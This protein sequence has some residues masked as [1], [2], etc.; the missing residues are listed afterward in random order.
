MNTVKNISCAV[1]IGLMLIIQLMNPTRAYAGGR[2]PPPPT[3]TPAS[4]EVPVTQ[5]PAPPAVAIETATPEMTEEAVVQAPTTTEQTTLAEIFQKLPVKIHV[6]ALNENGKALPLA[7]EEAADVIA[8]GDP[9]WCPAGQAPTPGTN[10]C[11][12]SYATLG[13]LVA[14]EGANIAADGTIWITTGVIPDVNVVTIDGITYTNWANNALTL[15]GGWDGTTG[16]TTISSN[17]VF[18]VPI[19]ITNWNTGI[20]IQ[21][22]DAPS[23]ALSNVTISNGN[24]ISL[25][26]ENDI[27]GVAN[28]NSNVKLDNVTVTGS[29]GTGIYVNTLGTITANNI[30]ANE[31]AVYGAMLQGEGGVTIN[32]TNEF[33]S[34]GGG[35]SV[36][37]DGDITLSNV[38]ATG[39][40]SW[41]AGLTS[42]YGNITM[43]GTNEF[44]NNT[45]H[46]FFARSFGDM[47]LNRITA[48]GNN[49]G[50]ELMSGGTMTVTGEFNSNVFNGLLVSFNNGGI[51]LNQVT[52]NWNGDTGI[53][54]RSIGNI[55]LNQVT[56][57]WNGT[58]NDEWN[59]DSGLLARSNGDFTLNQV[60]AHGNIGVGVALL[61]EEGDGDIIASNITANGNGGFGAELFSLGSHNITVTGTN[62][63]NDNA[64]LGLHA[65]TSGGNITLNNV[66]ANRNGSAGADLSSWGNITLTGTNEFND[67]K[68]GGLGVYTGAGNISLNSVTANGNGYNG[69]ILSSYYSGNV[70]LTGTNEFYNNADKGLGVFSNGHIALNNVTATGNETD[71]YLF[72][73]GN[74]T[75]NTATVTSLDAEAVCG[76]LALNEVFASNISYPVAGEHTFV[77]V[78]GQEITIYCDPKIYVDG[79]LLGE[80]PL[81]QAQY[82]FDLSCDSQ[83]L[84]PRDLPNGDKVTIV[85][86]VSGRAF[87]SRLDNTTIPTDLPAG[88]TYASAFSVNIMQAGKSIPVITEGG[89]IEVSF[90]VPSQQDNTYSILFWDNDRWIPLNDF[91]G[92]ENSPQTFQLNP[93][94]TA[95][96][97]M[98]ESGVKLV[99]R[100][101]VP[102]VEVSTNFPGIFVLA[103]H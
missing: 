81:L 46:G 78:F 65:Y 38:T 75:I 82:E 69:M 54:I 44:N 83:T 23:I 35:L 13:D 31:N 89:H 41:G 52:A 48:N 94:I 55:T 20:I 95:D 51:N 96:L 84:Y 26:S 70:T 34:N 101:G 61:S 57:N 59:E 77:D 98:I 63:F 7:G 74:A 11:T 73:P 80:L 86:P 36:T 8:E 10:G 49:Y 103:Q 87:I 45:G 15:Q 64:S 5:T 92:P 42:E 97:R 2:T 32:G 66:I 17:S 58:W 102:R 62:E 22:I 12:A 14:A 93:G 56:T 37:I 90:Q 76:T 18:S 60:T 40:S 9:V 24:N 27:Y 28:S 47:T 4:T 3:E 91:I 100:N 30:V 39:N 19:T 29:T 16:S 88:Y 67:N 99:T 53:D 79:Q 25:G 43:T 21:N 85:C 68:G 6:V 72:T 50:T 1:L 71:V 33:N